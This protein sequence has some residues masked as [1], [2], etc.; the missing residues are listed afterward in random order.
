MRIYNEQLQ[1]IAVHVRVSPGQF[2]T[3]RSHLAEAKISLIERGV[4]YLLARADR[5][6]NGAGRWAR[7]MIAVRGIPG[8]R[9]LQGFL[10]LAKKY[11]ANVISQA[12]ERALEAACFRLRPVRQ[13]CQ[14]Y[15]EDQQELAFSD[16]HAIIR[17]L[18]EY[19]KLLP[20]TEDQPETK[21]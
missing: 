5:L 2:H 17:P 8:V 6:G 7:Q 11:P 4:E 20:N 13:L 3:D 21:P 1:Q 18:A 16:E 14:R 12:G 10:S 9:V 19:Q 15:T